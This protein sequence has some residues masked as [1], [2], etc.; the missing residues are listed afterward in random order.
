MLI[1]LE[2]KRT[3]SGVAGRKVR[4]ELGGAG[5]EIANRGNLFNKFCCEGQPRR[6]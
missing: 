3:F 4:L 1:K 5:L 6:D 2:S